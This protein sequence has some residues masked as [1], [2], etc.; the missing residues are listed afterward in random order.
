MIGIC[1]FA[2][3]V[4]CYVLY[5]TFRKAY[6]FFIISCKTL[7]KLNSI[8]SC[9]IKGV[10]C[11]KNISHRRMISQHKNPRILILGGSLEYQKVQHKLA[12]IN[13][14]LEQVLFFFF[15]QLIFT[16]I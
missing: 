2:L 14:V 1:C 4:N 16:I 7:M 8:G 6:L 5:D 15:V 10:V 12:S 3:L 13:A 11:T 9:F